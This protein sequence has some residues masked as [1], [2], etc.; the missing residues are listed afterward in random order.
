MEGVDLQPIGWK[1]LIEVLMR[2]RY[3][4]IV[5]IP[6]RFAPRVAGTSNMSFKQQMHYMRHIGKLIVESPEDRR[7]YIFAGVGIAGVFVNM[8]VYVLLL[9]TNI[10]LWQAGCLSGLVAMFFNF[11]LNDRI[12]WRD[13][14]RIPALVR[15]AK[16]VGVSLVGIAINTGVLAL[17]EYRL[18]AHYFTSNLVGILVAMLW[19]YYGNNNWTWRAH[20][21]KVEVLFS[22]GTHDIDVTNV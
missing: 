15:L 17:L 2:G 5:E 9:R 21:T 16:Y 6:Y 12:T 18:D 19:S 3:D 20:K 10:Q 8:L 4:R 22:R 13:V 1:I 14:P 7:K 11:V